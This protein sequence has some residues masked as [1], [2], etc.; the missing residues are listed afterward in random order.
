M[1]QHRTATEALDAILCGDLGLD[2]PYWLLFL[3][4][5]RTDAPPMGAWGR[6]A[7]I[8]AAMLVVFCGLPLLVPALW[9]PPYLLVHQVYS[10]LWAAWA[11]YSSTIAS[12]AAAAMVKREIIPH[13][14][15][16]ADAALTSELETR[17]RPARIKARAWL[18]AVAAAALAGY[19]VWLDKAVPLVPAGDLVSLE[20]ARPS[21][22]AIVL[23]AIGS[24]ITFA[25]AARVVQT[26]AFYRVLP[27]YIDWNERLSF[28]LDPA[29][30]RPVWAVSTIARTMM[31]FWIGIA[32]SIALVLPATR[33]WFAFEPSRGYQA[34]VTLQLTISSFFALVP[35]VAVFLAVEADV[36]A[37]TRR[38]QLATL[39]PIERAA[40]VLL[41]R[42]ETAEAA[43]EGE[44]KQLKDLRDIHA[45]L[46]LTPSYR[47]MILGWLSILVPFLPLLGLLLNMLFK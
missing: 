26:A 47:S 8:F 1:P 35:S 25:A 30:T 28:R 32:V 37:A 41:S 13:L 36:R 15:P 29:N 21:T 3:K 16:E 23:F 11:T 22:P 40:N 42:I 33:G 14:S 9:L 20:D 31:L 24:A 43:D 4:R 12:G 7:F 17:F 38:Q 46:S 27:R 44:I 6:T 18:A 10:A 45:A 5:R 19:L 2:V 34:L 39:A